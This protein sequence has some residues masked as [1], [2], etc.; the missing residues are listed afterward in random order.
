MR[1]LRP[2]R[3]GFLASGAS[4]LAAPALGLA[5]DEPKPNTEGFVSLFNG[6]DLTGWTPKVRGYKLGENYGNTFRVA[7]G[8]LQVRYDKYEQF[9]EKFGHLFYKESFSHYI[10]RLEYRFV[11]DQCKGGPGW[12]TRNSGIMFHGQKPETMTLDQK[13]P[14]SI[15]YQ[16][17]GGL[18]KGARPTGNMCTPG[19]NVK[20]NEK[21]YTVHCTNSKSKTFDGDV[22]VTA[23]VEVH[24]SA[25]VIHRIN[26]EVVMEY[27]E[28][29]LD[30]KDPDAAPLVKARDGK[31]LIEEGS[32]SLQGESHP[33]D[34]R[35]I[36]IKLLKKD[37]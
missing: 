25:K 36:E 3:R 11:G 27:S 32:I 29:Q 10:L 23:E 6:K 1:S 8:L 26:G 14:V 4:L 34:F 35:K 7:D 31:L 17:L 5:A 28:P 22:W 12:A 20:Y 2:T 19:T 33:C 18:G 24:G 15:E 9:D 13:F 21:L 37:K 30:P 16:L